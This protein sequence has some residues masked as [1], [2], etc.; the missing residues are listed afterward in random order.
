MGFV[1]WDF[2]LQNLSIINIPFCVCLAILFWI[3]TEE[4][5]ARIIGINY[6]TFNLEHYFK[7]DCSL[8]MQFVRAKALIGYIGNRALKRAVTNIPTF[9]GFSPQI[10]AKSVSSYLQNIQMRSS[11]SPLS[12]N[13]Y[14][15]QKNVDV[16]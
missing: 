8:S 4:G 11:P 5:G 2:T 9:A 7:S 16:H 1:F 12:L 15:Q 3:L 13:I 14:K 10:G 6:T